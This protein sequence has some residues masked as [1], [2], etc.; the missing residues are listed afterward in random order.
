MQAV[1]V[2]VHNTESRN[3]NKIKLYYTLNENNYNFKCYVLYIQR[4]PL[5]PG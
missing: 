3:V 1:S 5:E 4:E 2:Q